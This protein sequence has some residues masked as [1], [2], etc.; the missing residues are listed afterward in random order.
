MLRPMILLSEADKK[1]D[2]EL[3]LSDP[4]AGDPPADDKATATDP[5]ASDD[6]AGGGADNVDNLEDDDADDDA[7]LDGADGSLDTQ[8]GTETD[9]V[10]ERIKRERLYDAIVD[11]QQQCEQLTASVDIVIDRIQDDTARKFAIQAR[12]TLADAADQC[13]IIRTRFADLGY[14]RTRDLYATIR[15]RVSAV[16]E[17]IKHVIDGDDDFRKP[18]S[19]T[20]QRNGSATE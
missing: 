10:A 3:D 1:A 6:A 20:P 5:A 9:E 4:T 17:I 19:G 15:E 2:D 14:E 8:Q 13:A 16:A 12:K 11:S 7:P 18:D